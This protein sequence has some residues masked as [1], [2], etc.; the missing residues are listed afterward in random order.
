MLAN[1]IF[2]IEDDES[3]NEKR[4]VMLSKTQY[5]SSLMKKLKPPLAALLFIHLGDIYGLLRLVFWCERN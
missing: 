3:D 2:V 1:V 4:L 5:V